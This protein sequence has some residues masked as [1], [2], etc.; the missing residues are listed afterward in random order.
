M[1]KMVWLVRKPCIVFDAPD[2]TCESVNVTLRGNH[3]SEGLEWP[4]GLVIF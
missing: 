4:S 2:R 1:D 3:K